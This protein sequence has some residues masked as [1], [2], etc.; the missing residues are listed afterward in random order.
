MAADHEVLTLKEICYILRV[1]PATVYK[2]IR[3]GK[4]PSFR[5]GNEWRFSKDVIMR[6]MLN[7]LTAPSR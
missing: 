3:E 2:L 5:V 4:I 1:H 7:G 6:W